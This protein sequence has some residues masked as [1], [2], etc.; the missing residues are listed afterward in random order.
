LVA[1][2]F[3]VAAEFALVASRRHRIEQAADKGE[4]G[5]KAALSGLREISLMLA[6]AQLGI[7]M[8]VV[9][10]GMVSEPA[11]HHML[12]PVLSDLGLAHAVSQT[13]ALLVALVVVTFLHVVVGEMAPKSW[14]IAHPERSA[15]LLAPPFRGF[16]WLLR[17]L[18][19][20]LNGLTNALLRLCRVS[21]R[22]EVVHVRNREQIHH[23]V[24]ESRRLG[25]IGDGDHGL[26]ARTLDA[27]DLPVSD[28]MVQASEIVEVHGASGPDD[29]IAT[30]QRTGRTRMIV[31]DDR[32]H[33]VGAV[34]VREALVA[35]S[36]NV[37]WT[38][39]SSATL[40][41]RMNESVD[42]ANAAEVL[43]VARAQLGLVN[44]ARGRIVGLV[45]MDDLAT[46]ILMSP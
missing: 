17:W 38:A 14:A 13:L 28:V 41:P 30:A 21:P 20:G 43:R 15:M 1:S 42:L 19:V 31:R 18:L 37:S 2:G 16:T 4:R 8:V 10:L 33:I 23:L 44:D 22:D 45:T 39:G 3:F 27:P 36:K 7:T 25:L 46:K 29:V 35:R 11:F 6:G 24:D 34:H 40:V 5:A 12:E 9:G 26:L 32:G